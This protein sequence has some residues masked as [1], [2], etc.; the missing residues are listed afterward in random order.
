MTDIPSN[1]I[2]NLKGSCKKAG[3]QGLLVQGQSAGAGQSSW[4]FGET[5][6]LNIKKIS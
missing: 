3:C 6:N 1:V 2:K 4:S 5:I